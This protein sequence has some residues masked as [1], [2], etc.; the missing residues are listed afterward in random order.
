MT[1]PHRV[2][3]VKVPAGEFAMG[4]HHGDGYPADGEKPVHPVRLSAFQIDAV[5]VT[6]AAFAEFV[7][8]TGY[9]TTAEEAGASAVFQGLVADDADVVGRS[10]GASWWVAVRGADWAHPFGGT[11]SLEGLEDHPVVHVSWYDASAYCRWA[12]RTL[13]TEAQ[14]ERAARGSLTGAR[15]PWGD[16]LLDPEGRWR[17]N[18][19]QGDFPTVNTVDDGYAGTAP[20]RTYAPNDVGLWQPTGNVWE[21]CADFFDARWYRN[22]DQLDPIGPVRGRRRV[23]RGGSYL[24][25][26][27]YCN[28]YRVAARSANTP[29]SSMG[30]AGF[31]T[32]AVSPTGRSV[33][34]G[35]GV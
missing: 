17:C 30:N 7:D 33:T 24:C 11:A 28:R 3:Q 31:R 27:S 13:P 18:I 20:V 21:W 10:S 35:A 26:D 22:A 4:D 9:R 23:L 34:D 6:N 8:S 29:E 2:E 19:W 14:W 12:N 5:T 1:G 16:T 25:H 32:V 15:Y